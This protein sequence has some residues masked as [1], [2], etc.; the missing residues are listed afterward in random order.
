MSEKVTYKE[1]RSARVRTDN[2]V[3]DA[4]MYDIAAD[5]SISGSTAE[6]IDSGEVKKD[7]N[8]VANFA[9]YGESNLSINYTGA[10]S[11]EQCNILEAVQAFLTDVRALASADSP[12]T[13]NA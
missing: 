3:D 10:E 1:L 9:C 8:A 4:R 5:V 12:V 13:L 7:G 2:S 11:A 6:S